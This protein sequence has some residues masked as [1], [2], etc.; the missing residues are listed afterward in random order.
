MN[1]PEIIRKTKKLMDE[2]GGT[3]FA[4][5]V[6]EENPFSKYAVVVYAGGKY[7]VYPEAGNIS[8]AATGV[9][10]IIEE[11]NKIGKRVTYQKDARLISH[12]AQIN[13]SDV[14][15]RRLRNNPDYFEKR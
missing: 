8:L 10:T 12:S 5:P 6:E 15:M 7:H 3:I 14:T 2:L 1:K 4:F 13:A 11:F 9:L